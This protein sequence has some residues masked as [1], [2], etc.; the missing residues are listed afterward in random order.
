[1]RWI[2][3]FIKECQIS[4]FNSSL[5]YQAQEVVKALRK[6]VM[7]IPRE[8]SFFQVVSTDYGERV[9]VANCDENGKYPDLS[10]LKFFSKL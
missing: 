5:Y 10:N 3:S 6:R 7:I 8:E 1:M 9:F 4:T 2:H